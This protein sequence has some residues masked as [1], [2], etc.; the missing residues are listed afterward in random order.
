[1]PVNS[2]WLERTNETAIEPE[3]P[4]CDPHH[5]LW[6]HPKSRYLLDELLEDTG[7]GHDVRETVFLECSSM[8]RKD[9][10]Q[11]MKPVGETEFAQ[12]I[13]AQ[14]ASGQYGP[15]IVAAGIVGFADLMLGSQ[16]ASVLEAHL[17]A[18]PNRFRG[19]RNSCSWDE[20][21]AIRVSHSNP[22]RELY[23][24]S[25]FREGFA[26]L[27]QYDLTFDAWL[28]HPQIP[29]LVSLARAFPE[30]S[31]ICDHFA[32]PLGIGPYAGKREEVFQYWKEG[33]REL[34]TCPN[35]VVKLGGLVMAINGFG[36]HKGDKPPTSDELVAA[37]SPYYR[38]TIEQFGP[39]RCMFESNFP[40]DK[41]SCSYL[42]L[43]NSFKKM[44]RDFST[45]ERAALFRDTA[46]RVYR[47]SP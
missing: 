16:V 8:Y 3:L 43:W 39:N 28:F 44:T 41:V 10:P 2:S 36:F 46:I 19:I 17:A 30:T 40:V 22:P 35:V 32:G 9:G 26:A 31:I 18:S 42:V 24:N 38:F 14:S 37:T 33:I 45:T 25:R 23:L 29:E 1:M 27:R 5:H 13:A 7:S 4:V 34:A 21:P 15:T 20:S 47:L 6:D 12:G 11:E